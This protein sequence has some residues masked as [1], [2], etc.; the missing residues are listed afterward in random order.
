MINVKHYYPLDNHA[1]FCSFTKD[2]NWIHKDSHEDYDLIYC[3]DPLAYQEIL[4]RPRRG[5]LVGW[6]W[7]IPYNWRE[8]SYDFYQFDFQRDEYINYYLFCLSRCDLVLCGTKWTQEVLRRF[9]IKAIPI[10]W[11]IPN[12]AN[13]EYH[14]HD[15]DG[16]C[17][18]SR[19]FPPKRFEIPIQACRHISEKIVSCGFAQTPD[20]LYKIDKLSDTYDE[21]YL[22]TDAQ[23]EEIPIIIQSSKA[24]IS[25][26]VFE[27][28]GLTPSEALYCDTPIFLTDIPVFR[29]FYG[30]CAVFFEKD[31]YE[32]LATKLLNTTQSELNEKLLI[33]KERIKDVTPQGFARRWRDVVNKRF[34]I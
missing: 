27:G 19:I 30:D 8:W 21:S 12:T 9:G 18:I 26:S 16:Y 5:P 10:D 14:K 32:D 23:N 25:A 11:Y 24:L 33:G 28:W 15:R 13:L 31:N 4:K 34:G 2:V 1:E 20:Y 29:E 3:S 22:I 17:Q 7:D 6:C